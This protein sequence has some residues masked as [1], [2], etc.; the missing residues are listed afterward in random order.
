MI[1]FREVNNDDAEQVLRWRTEPRISSMMLTDVE[2]DLHKQLQWIKD[3]RERPDYYHWIFQ[4]DGIDVGLSS[5]W[6]VPPSNATMNI[7]FY[8]GVTQYGFITIPV[9]QA[10]Y[11]Y[12]FCHLYKERIDLQMAE[13]NRIITIQKFF[14][15]ERNPMNDIKIKRSNTLVNFLGYSLVRE[16]FLCKYPSKTILTFPTDMRKNK[17]IWSNK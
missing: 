12:I 3:S 17:N 5:I 6:T 2:I 13:G 14:G 9:L 1:S 11:N 4:K 16:N 15:F 7:G 10:L 8:V